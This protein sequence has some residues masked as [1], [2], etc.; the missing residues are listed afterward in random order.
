MLSRSVIGETLM[1]NFEKQGSAEALILPYERMVA[2]YNNGMS[3]SERAALHAWEK[4]NV[5]GD[6][7]LGTSHWP[8][9]AEIV[10]RLSH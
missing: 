2:M 3:D 1:S 7:A 10:K 9:W 5:K 4:E 8:G 6:G